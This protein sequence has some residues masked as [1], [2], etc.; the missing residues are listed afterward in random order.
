MSVKDWE[1]KFIYDD[2]GK[3]IRTERVE[4]E[5]EEKE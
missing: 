4:L 1:I 3:F 2:S 5:T